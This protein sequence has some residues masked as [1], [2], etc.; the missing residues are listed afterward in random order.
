MTQDIVRVSLMIRKDQHDS[1]RNMD[2]NISGYIRDLIDDRLCDDTIIL[3]VESETKV[4]YDQI[5][6]H[7]GQG[8]HDFEPYIRAALKSM[9]AD[10]IKKLQALHKTM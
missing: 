10:K 4:I 8:D 1:L 7:S 2:V 5:I 9:L 6:S 3:S